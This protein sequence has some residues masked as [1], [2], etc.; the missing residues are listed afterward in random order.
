MSETLLIFAGFG[1]VL[2][3]AFHLE[4]KITLEVIPP[5]DI[6]L[7]L[8]GKAMKKAFRAGGSYKNAP[9][10]PQAGMS[11]SNNPVST[12]HLTLP[13]C[14]QSHSCPNIGVIAI[15]PISV[16]IEDSSTK[17]TN[18]SHLRFKMS[19]KQRSDLFRG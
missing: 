18:S 12:C 9:P 4:T 17:S 6:L 14:D 3:K 1:T 7:F 15:H 16:F 19:S 5:G 10:C 11:K 8:Q 2:G 13:I